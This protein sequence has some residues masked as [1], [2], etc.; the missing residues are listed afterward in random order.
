MRL[1][2]NENLPADCI[3][4]LRQDGH[5]VL[6]IREAAPGSSDDA[7]LARARDEK[8][9]LITFDKDFGEL[10]FRRGAKASQGIVLFRI[11]Q[12]S[13]AVVAARIAAILASREDWFGNFSIVEEFVIRIRP[14]PDAR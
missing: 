8:R 1:C 11:A 9:L 14:L 10:V 2:A 7:V 6:W 12:P 5:D 13:A 3:L 4:R